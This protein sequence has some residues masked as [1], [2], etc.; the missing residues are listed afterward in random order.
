MGRH[1]AHMTYIR[2]A[3]K[4]LGEKPEGKRQLGRHMHRWENNIKIDLK[5]RD[6]IHLYQDRDQWLVLVNSNKPSDSTKGRKYLEYLC[7]CHLL[8][9]D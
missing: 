3:Y 6:W 5:E 2:N 8:K 1:T 9:K 4:I 7:N